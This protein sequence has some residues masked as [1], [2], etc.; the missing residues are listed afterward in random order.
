MSD[1]QDDGKGP[2]TKAGDDEETAWG[3]GGIVVVGGTGGEGTTTR[4]EDGG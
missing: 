2:T 3:R 4:V 1:G